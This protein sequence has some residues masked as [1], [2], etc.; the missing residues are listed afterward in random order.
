MPLA[1][2][3][4]SLVNIGLI[5]I[6]ISPSAFILP[7]NE[8]SSILVPVLIFENSFS[9]DGV[10]IEYS[11]ILKFIRVYVISLTMLEVVFKETLVKNAVTMDLFAFT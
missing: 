11:F 2:I 5:F 6:L 8:I 7:I 1:V 9:S 10:L 4:F 3:P